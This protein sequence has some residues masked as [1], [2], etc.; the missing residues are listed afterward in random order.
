LC[1]SLSFLLLLLTFLHLFV[2]T[3]NMGNAA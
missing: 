2:L 1:F 3:K